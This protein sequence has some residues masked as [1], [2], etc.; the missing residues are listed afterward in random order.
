[1]RILHLDHLGPLLW[2]RVIVCAFLAALVSGGLLLIPTLEAKSEILL[3]G[4]SAAAREPVDRKGPQAPMAAGLQ[5]VSS[6]A[7]GGRCWLL[8]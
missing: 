8:K 6:A 3:Q 1:M 7:D 2:G 4:G 5:P